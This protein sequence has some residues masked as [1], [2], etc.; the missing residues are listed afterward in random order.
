MP[1]KYIPIPNSIEDYRLELEQCESLAEK[2]SSIIRTTGVRKSNLL[3]SELPNLSMEAKDKIVGYREK[4]R[5]LSGLVFCTAPNWIHSEK[6]NFDEDAAF[7]LETMRE[8]STPGSNYLRDFDESIE[9]FFQSI[10][11]VEHTSME[12]IRQGSCK[13]SFN[14]AV[15]LQTIYIEC[16]VAKAF[17][18]S[19][20]I[21]DALSSYLTE[22]Q[23]CILHKATTEDR[24]TLGSL[25]V[26][27]I[28][29]HRALSE[30]NEEVLSWL[31]DRFQPYVSRYRDESEISRFRLSTGNLARCLGLLREQYRNPLIHSRSGIFIMDEEYGRFSDLAY[32]TRHLKQWLDLGLNPYYYKPIYFGWVS[33]LAAA[34]YSVKCSGPSKNC[35][36]CEQSVDTLSKQ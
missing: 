27:S 3:G 11:D 10:V 34:R 22:G 30:D 15:I 13:A 18:D 35:T 20:I 28:G 7:D 9:V 31:S 14:N 29:L 2:V 8:V 36:S 23:S 25:Q 33:F 12:Q 6:P 21:I 17:K 16:L 5:S 24:H 32:G 1:K 19:N 4:L 26:L